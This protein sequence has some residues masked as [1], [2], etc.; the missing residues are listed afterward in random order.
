LVG[1]ELCMMFLS[2]KDVGNNNRTGLNV[3]P[4]FDSS[5]LHNADSGNI[6]IRLFRFPLGTYY[7]LR[8][9]THP[10]FR[11]V[12]TMCSFPR[13]SRPESEAEFKDAWRC[14]S[15]LTSL[16]LQPKLGV[17]SAVSTGGRI[18]SFR[19]HI[20]IKVV[21]TV[22]CNTVASQPLCFTCGN[23]SAHMTSPE[24]LLVCPM[25]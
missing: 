20:L 17:L 9:L 4:F 25:R 10:A 14:T 23:A 13:K 11:S 2:L 21:S 18:R 16:V 6:N 12:A 24:T 15:R 5:I 22:T 8:S 7:F 1:L 3:K 19:P